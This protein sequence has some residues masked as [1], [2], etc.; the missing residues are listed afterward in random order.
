MQSQS[1]CLHHHG[2]QHPRAQHGVAEDATAASGEHRSV[3]HD[4]LKTNVPVT[5]VPAGRLSTVRHGSSAWESS[6]SSLLCAGGTPGAF[7]MVMCG[8]TFSQG[9]SPSLRTA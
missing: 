8:R 5:R 2:H 9:N 6:S 3:S 1:R 7:A 4:H